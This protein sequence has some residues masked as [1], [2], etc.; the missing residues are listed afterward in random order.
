MA[1]Q[2]QET[3]TQEPGSLGSNPQPLTNFKYSNRV[4]LKSLFLN[5]N[6]GGAEFI[7]QTVVVGGWVKSSKEVEISSPPPPPSS[8]AAENEAPAKD[9]SCVEIFQS[10]IPLI[11]NIMEVLG[12]NSYVSRKK[13]RDSPIPT[14]LPPKSSTAYLLLTDGSCVATLQVVVESSIATPSRLL[15]TGTCIIVEGRLERPSAEGK[16]AIQLKAE[17][18]LHIGTVDVGK[19]PLSKKRVP[20]DMLRDY[21][22][23]RPRT[24]TVATVM[25]VRSALSFA[26]HSFFKDHA[27]FDVQ[28]PTITTTDTEGFSNMFQVTTTGNQKADKEKLSTIYETEGVNLET[29]KEAVK[30]KSKLVETL[31]R[32]ESNKEA[33][34]AAIQDLHKTNELA[35]QLE[36]REKKKFGTSLK[37]DRVDSSEDFFSTK[38]YLTVSGRLHLE[39]F[40]SALGNVYSFGP[41]FQADKTDSA[42]HAAEMWMVEAEMAFAELKDSMNCAN[43]LFKHLCKWVLENHSDDV[44]F[45]GKRIDNTCIERLR[46]IISG[47]PQ[48]ISYNEA[49]DVLRKAEDKKSEAKFDSGARL[50]SDHLSYLADAI[51]KQP[52]IIH[53]YPKE[54]KPFYVR[55]NDDKTVAA[56]DLIVP[57][58]GTIISGS[59]NEDR[60][61]MISSRM[62]E[63]GLP[64]EKY[65]WYLDL[66]RNGTVKHAGFTLNFDLMVLF[67][68][69]LSNVR[70]VIP[71]PRSYGKANN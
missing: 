47:S 36:G 4:Q 45:V 71:F 2:N 46:Q 18:V 30:E 33:L 27:F 64:R 44:K 51:Y 9:V 28:V 58:V 14:P 35:L 38:T 40:A 61:T 12:G 70:D 53:S 3:Q 13:L 60:L 32:S 17:K 50:T 5:R 43:D 22:H 55:V 23:F 24:T 16:H 20:L 59:Q 37:H 66:C 31:K 57:K 67:M 54:A 39:S 48:L 41:R 52:I 63:L 65:E 29:M 19:Y 68:T 7:G 56:F 21:A 1:K 8:T 11:R 49:L 26:T 25:R 15:A 62:T 6:D 34:A 42:K 69:G 10:R